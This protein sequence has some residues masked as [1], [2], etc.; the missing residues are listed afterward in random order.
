MKYISV[1]EAAKK[2]NISERSVRNYCSL[3][4]VNGAILD[5]KTWLIPE[6]SNKPERINGK[7]ISV[8][9]EADDLRK[10]LNDSPVSFY[11]VKYT[12]DYLLNY[13]YQLCDES[14]PCTFASG[15]K[16][17][18]KRNGSS[19]VAVDIGGLVEKDNCCF[20]I[21]AS[22]SDSPCFKL[23][24]ECDGKTDIYNKVNVEPYGGMICS[25]WLD[26]PLGIAG[27]VMIKENGKII[28]KLVNFDED[29][30][31]IP[32]M[33]IHFNREINTGYSY[34]MASDMQAYIGQELQDRP[35]K[36]L[37]IKKLS[38]KEE[39]ILNFDLY[40]YNREKATIWGQNKEYISSPRLDD[41]ECVYA[42]RQALA[43]SYNARAINI[44]YISDNEEVGSSSRQGADSDFLLS[45]VNRIIESFGCSNGDLGRITANSFMISADNAHAVHPNNPGMT[46]A[47][48]KC[49]MNKG[50]AIKFNASQSYTSDSVSSSIFQEICNKAGVPYQFFSNR[51]DKRGGSTLGNILLSHLS[52]RSVDV[53]LPQLAM[54]SSFETAGTKDITYAINAFKMFYSSDILVEDETYQIK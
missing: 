14:K 20:H 8:S 32:N 50:I 25:T 13:G 43:S 40:L 45:I 52:F 37:L 29:L 38:V 28:T 47:N 6:D 5:G 21:I 36:D 19:L 34:N 23:K 31:I 18:F 3:G 7:E 42:S 39:N 27:R 44:M 9:S 22:H 10:F 46:D 49:Y 53:G 24:P 17:L 11:A 4:R 1:I 30:L 2:W 12:C 35:I 51:S 16:Y 48:N 33:C 54:H 15:K 41:L 26:R